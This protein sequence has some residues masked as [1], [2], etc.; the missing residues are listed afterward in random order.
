[1]ANTA[2]APKLDDVLAQVPR[3]RR[4]AIE[5]RATELIA[6]E[7]SLRE[8]RKALALTQ[9][10]VARQLDKGQH[11]ISR[12]EHR[13]DMLLS[14]LTRDCLE[15]ERD[16]IRGGA[17]YRIWHVMGEAVANVILSVVLVGPMGING[18]ALGTAIP[19]IIVI[20]VMLPMYAC[21]LLG[22]SWWT[23]VRQSLTGPLLNMLPFLAGAWLVKHY[24]APTSLLGFFGI[25]TLLTVMYLI[26]GYWLCLRADERVIASGYAARLFARFSGAKG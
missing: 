12:I 6:E 4:R 7:M 5:R 17:R 9:C 18:V 20:G 21:K 23:Y 16:I 14:T 26:S 10:D 25:I 19:H 2:A 15:R 1:M 8:L 3:T 24:A 13:G 22:V 11:E